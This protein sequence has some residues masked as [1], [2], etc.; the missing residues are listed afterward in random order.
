V[1]V[2]WQKRFRLDRYPIFQEIYHCGLAP[3]QLLRIS[4]EF[5]PLSEIG[6]KRLHHGVIRVVQSN[7]FSEWGWGKNA[8]A[9][10]RAD[11]FRV[12][13]DRVNELLALLGPGVVGSPA[14]GKPREGSQELVGDLGDE[15]AH[16]LIQEGK[17]NPTWRNILRVLP[18]EGRVVG[19]VPTETSEL[20]IGVT[21]GGALNLVRM[22][23][24]VLAKGASQ[25]R[26]KALAAVSPGRGG[27]RR[28]GPTP[29]SAFAR[30]L[31]VLY[32]EMRRRYPSSGLAPGYS[33]GGPLPRFVL[34]VF[35]AVRERD[36]D[37]RPISDASIGSLFYEVRK[38]NTTEH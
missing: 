8:P 2:M 30:D 12:V 29:S 6:R 18:A 14:D 36:P 38:S 23:L 7:W 19:G 10:T 28:K 16:V 35:D 3:A 1:I 31:V 22:A 20:P 13:E 17:N 9:S 21:S 37:L 15:T 4:D 34:A 32:C 25:A 24:T 11:R 26:A 27:A 5:G 33:R